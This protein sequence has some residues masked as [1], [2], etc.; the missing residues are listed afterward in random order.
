[1]FV[2]LMVVFREALTT[3]RAIAVCEASVALEVPKGGTGSSSSTSTSTPGALK[4]GDVILWRLRWLGSG[5]PCHP[6][7]GSP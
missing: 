5:R 7:V 1:M 3:A 2:G 6:S 4:A